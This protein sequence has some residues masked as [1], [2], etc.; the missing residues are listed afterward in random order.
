MDKEKDQQAQDGQQTELVLAA[1]ARLDAPGAAVAIQTLI[2]RAKR[3]SLRAKEP[4]TWRK[5]SLELGPIPVVLEEQSDAC[6]E[7][8]GPAL[9]AF[10][11][12]N[13]RNA[14]QDCTVVIIDRIQQCPEFHAKTHQCRPG[15]G[16]LHKGVVYLQGLLAYP[17]PPRCSFGRDVLGDDA[18]LRNEPGHE[19]S[20]DDAGE[21]YQS[22]ENRLLSHL[23]SI[24][25]ARCPTA[26]G[27]TKDDADNDCRRRRGYSQTTPSPSPSRMYRYAGCERCTGAIP[28]PLASA[29]VMLPFPLSS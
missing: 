20:H 25:R 14:A 5:T 17:V 10:V 26:K 12:C 8:L 13:S 21:R 1:R 9:F 22:D 19:G 24:K 27:P 29:Q 23:C 2:H 16:T 18:S 3:S 7:L 11:R 4:S 15:S 6:R 28:C